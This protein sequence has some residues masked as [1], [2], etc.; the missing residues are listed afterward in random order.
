MKPHHIKTVIV[1][2]LAAISTACSHVSP[3]YTLSAT[4]VEQLRQ[5]SQGGAAKISAGEF[6]A[7]EV[8]KNS[9]MCRAA[10]PIEAPNNQPF[11]QF[12]KDAIFDELK[13]ANLVDEK[14]PIKLRAKL[15]SIDFNSN[16]GAGKWM[17]KMT[18]AS[19]GVDP[20]TVENTYSFSTNFIADIAC[21]QVAQ[22]LPAATQAFI[23][24][25]FEHPGFKKIIGQSIAKN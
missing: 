11:D 2:L 9:I 8:G 21:E 5:I 16:I 18:F 7:A 24:K 13:L 6:T 1:I 25:V 22:A 15:D 4:N 10:G 20:F 23:K 17:M 3:K 14:S 19:D 12:I